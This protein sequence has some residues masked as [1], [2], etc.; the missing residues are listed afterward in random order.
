M[1]KLTPE[2]ARILKKRI[3]AALDKAKYYPATVDPELLAA[4]VIAPY[5]PKEKS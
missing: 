1:D 4:E 2:L 5:L 3:A